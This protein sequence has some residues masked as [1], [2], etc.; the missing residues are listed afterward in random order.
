[1]FSVIVLW[2]SPSEIKLIDEPMESLVVVQEERKVERLKIKNKQA[3][4]FILDTF[5]DTFLNP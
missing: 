5:L 3:M 2:Y 4:N 1:M